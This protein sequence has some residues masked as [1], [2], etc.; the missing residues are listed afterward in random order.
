M[1]WSDHKGVL[2]L[3]VTRSS[4]SLSSFIKLGLLAGSQAKKSKKESVVHHNQFLAYFHT[5]MVSVCLSVCVWGG[6][7]ELWKTCYYLKDGQ[8]TEGKTSWCV[9]HPSLFSCISL[10]DMVIWSYN[11]LI[12]SHEYKESECF[13]GS[14]VLK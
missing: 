3:K 13:F 12:R 4:W 7:I 6:P 2:A 8:L 5:W 9:S 1:D 10:C 14:L 11:R